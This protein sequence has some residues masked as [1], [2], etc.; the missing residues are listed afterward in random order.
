MSAAEWIA[1]YGYLAVL[2]GS[3]LEGESILMLAGFAAHQGYLDL[4]AVLLIAFVAGSLGDQ[5]FFWFGRAS[6]PLLLQRFDGIARAGGRIAPLLKRHDAL[7]IFGIRFM[8]GLRI[9]GPVAMGALDVVPRRFAIFNVLGAAVW[10]PL[11][12]GAG[13]L[14]GRTLQ[15]L[16]GDIERYEGAILAVIVGGAVLLA[17]AHHWWQ[18]RQASRE[19]P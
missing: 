15:A 2:V 1:R 5:A 7:L 14:F 6:G 3:F 11:I 9:A 10:A 4:R 18:S 12:G 19:T 17:L 13:Y 16:L 8:Y